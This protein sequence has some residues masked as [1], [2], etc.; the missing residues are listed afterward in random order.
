MS[1]V[2]LASMKLQFILAS[3]SLDLLERTVTKVQKYIYN[4]GIFSFDLII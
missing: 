3:V 1:M 4:F 2:E